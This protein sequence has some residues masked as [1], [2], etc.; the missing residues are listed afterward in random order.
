M[1][2]K[3]VERIFNQGRDEGE[4]SDGYGTRPKGWDNWSEAEQI[5]YWNS[6]PPEVQRRNAY[7]YGDVPDRA[8]GY[9]SAAKGSAVQ[10]K[11]EAAQKSAGALAAKEQADNKQRIDFSNAMGRTSAPRGLD[12]TNQ[13]VGEQ[14]WDI[15]QDD[16]FR[17]GEA[18]QFSAAN[19]GAYTTQGFGETRGTEVSNELAKGGAGEKYWE[20]IQGRYNNGGPDYVQDAYGSF[21]A[22]VDPGLGSYYDRAFQQASQGINKQLAARGQYGSSAGMQQLGNVATGLGAERANREAAYGLERFRTKMG[23]AATASGDERAW[24]QGLGDMAFRAGDER[25][26]YLGDSASVAAGVQGQGF[27]RLGQGYSQAAQN[28]QFGLANRN[29]GFAQA[30]GAQDRRDNRIQQGFDNQIGFSSVLA[31]MGNNRIQNGYSAAT[32]GAEAGLGA[33][34]DNYNSKTASDERQY[35]EYLSTYKGG[36]EA[37]ASFVPQKPVD[38]KKKKVP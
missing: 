25:R 9:V 5:E 11:A 14:L 15:R 6:L 7:A 21:D 13:G 18:S 34:T 3:D 8:K 35:Q 29:S 24:V 37:L 20:G 31:A 23:A 33:A 1:G 36:A 16:F 2:K 26:A 27:D 30:F 32:G 38:P 19:K 22:A 17:P 4:D 12:Q 28:D 10:A